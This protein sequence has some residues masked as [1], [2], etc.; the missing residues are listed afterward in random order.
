MAGFKR[1][2][3]TT[4]EAGLKESR[5][6][7]AM[8]VDMAPGMARLPAIIKFTLLI[9]RF[10]VQ[11]RYLHSKKIMSHC[12]FIFLVSI[13]VKYCYLLELELRTLSNYINFEGFCPTPCLLT[14]LV[15]RLIIACCRA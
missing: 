10:W 14:Q 5:L 7:P 1:K 2:R 12:A 15:C 6:A 8:F 11:D 4:W 3:L 13:L 9:A